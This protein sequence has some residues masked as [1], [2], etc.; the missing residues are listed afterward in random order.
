MV[1]DELGKRLHDRATRGE[2]LSTQER[3]QLEG[4]YAS[5]DRTEMEALDLPATE[6]V[7]ILQAQVDSVL[8]Q[9]ET[10]AKRIQEISRENEELRTEIAALHH[11]L[12]KQAAGRAA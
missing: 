4:W 6:T 10:A 12:A 3:D 1:S 2:S 11:R 5:Q 9:L 8:D 7:V